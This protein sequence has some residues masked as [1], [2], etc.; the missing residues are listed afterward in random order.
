MNPAVRFFVTIAFE[1]KMWTL[2]ICI[3]W[4]HHS[5]NYSSDI[6]GNCRQDFYDHMLH[7]ALDDEKLDED[8]CLG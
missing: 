3:E 2:Y 1:Q 4:R 7:M 6:L 8:L 5:P